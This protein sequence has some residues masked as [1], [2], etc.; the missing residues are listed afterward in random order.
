MDDIGLE[1]KVQKLLIEKIGAMKNVE[2]FTSPMVNTITMSTAAVDYK[3]IAR[4]G[5]SSVIHQVANNFQFSMNSAGWAE[6][7]EVTGGGG[8]LH[9]CISQFYE[10]AY[11][12]NAKHASDFMNNNIYEKPSDRLRIL[13]SNASTSFAKSSRQ[14]AV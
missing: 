4:L 9:Y 2:D 11:H 14:L 12:L 13:T 5:S 8:Y 6:C 10:S 3:E 7:V 1:K